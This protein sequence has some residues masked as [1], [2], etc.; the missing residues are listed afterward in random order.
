MRAR[1]VSALLAVAAATLVTL[2]GP[3]GTP[4]RPVGRYEAILHDLVARLA[5]ARRSG[6]SPLLVDIDRESLEAFPRPL[7]MYSELLARCVEN[8]ADAGVR[9]VGVDLTWSF[10]PASFEREAVP[11]D[12]ALK[13][14]ARR[15]LSDQIAAATEA[16][17]ELTQVREPPLDLA[18]SEMLTLRGWQRPPRAWSTTARSVAFSSL[19]PDGDGV[20]RQYQYRAGSRIALA[21]FLLGPDARV[22]DTAWMVPG[23]PQPSRLSFRDC[24]GGRVRERLGTPPP[25]TAL[26]AAC[27]PEL[28]DERRVVGHGKVCGGFIH[29]VAF[30]QVAASALPVPAPTWLRFGVALLGGLVVTAAFSL[31]P[32][33]GVALGTVAGVL[34]TTAL[35]AWLLGRGLFAPALYALLAPA[36][37][38]L[39]TLATFI[40]SEG[41]ERRRLSR[42]LGAYLPRPAL[43]R[44]LERGESGI[45]AGEQLE[46]VAVFSDVTSYTAISELLT[47]AGVV[48]LLNE[49]FTAVTDAAVAEGGWIEGYVADLVVTYFPVLPGS[50]IA[51]AAEASERAWRAARQMLAGRDRLLARLDDILPPDAVKGD[52]AASLAK[53]RSLFD[54]GIG[55]HRGPAVLGDLG[56]KHLRKFSAMGDTMNAASRIEG[57]TRKL[58]TRLLLSAEATEHLDAGSFR[59]LAAVRVKGRAEPVRLYEDCSVTARPT[60]LDAALDAWEGGRREVFDR[61]LAEHP[62]LA[63]DPLVRL[64][65]AHAGDAPVLRFDEK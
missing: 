39:G 31:R 55:L 63:A 7:A 54:Y 49:H 40:T 25:A 48:A 8:L 3:P 22:P 45:L 6:H 14:E 17:T 33:L 50:G 19:L 1:V 30:E 4:D 41:R 28:R 37:T 12:L 46:L 57:L 16:F 23:D 2:A 13:P 47:P 58:G 18:F 27:A 26:L 29:L 32:G 53:I 65:A 56:G 38:G 64:L 11:D 34:L 44:I 36:L 62:D 61:L 42:A 59:R 51:T 35:L 21:T 60:A 15:V 9:R 20:V 52:R 10:D 43:S 5:P 24:V